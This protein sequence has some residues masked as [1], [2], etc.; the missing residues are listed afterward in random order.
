MHNIRALFITYRVLLN[1]LYPGN[2]QPYF[3]SLLQTSHHD[4]KVETVNN[5]NSSCI[6]FLL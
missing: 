5:I 3:L 1:R 6:L 4:R 2:M